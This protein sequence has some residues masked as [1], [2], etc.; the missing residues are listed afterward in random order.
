MT[1]TGTWSWTHCLAAVARAR[2]MSPAMARII[3]ECF[4]LVFLSLPENVCD[5]MPVVT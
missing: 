2:V 3:E 1:G 4:M 5:I